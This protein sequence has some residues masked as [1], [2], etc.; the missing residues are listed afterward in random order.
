MANKRQSPRRPE[1]PDAASG[2][3]RHGGAGPLRPPWESHRRRNR[4]VGE[5]REIL[6]C[7]ARLSGEARYSINPVLEIAGRRQMWV[8]SLRNCDEYVRLSAKIGLNG[9]KKPLPTT[10]ED[11]KCLSR[12]AK[13]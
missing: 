6:W 5:G 4:K 10:W 13:R 2:P 8:T 9:S 12:V 3:R 11:S 7:K 1:G